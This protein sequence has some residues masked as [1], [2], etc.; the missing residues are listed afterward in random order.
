LLICFLNLSLYLRSKS[1]KVAQTI[2]ICI[3]AMKKGAPEATKNAC[4]NLIGAN[5][6]G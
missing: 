3:E 5:I 1:I 6:L 4:L 2:T